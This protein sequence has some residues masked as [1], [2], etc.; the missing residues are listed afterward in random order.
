MMNQAA[1]MN[2]NNF[3]YICIQSLKHHCKTDSPM[4]NNLVL[5]FSI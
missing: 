1:R 5:L 3:Y 4:N 2:G